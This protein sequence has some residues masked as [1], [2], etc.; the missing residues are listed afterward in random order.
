[1][2][3]AA[4]AT[5]VEARVRLSNRKGRIQSE[6]G[7]G[8]NGSKSSRLEVREREGEREREERGNMETI[9]DQNGQ[10][11]CW[12]SFPLVPKIEQATIEIY[13]MTR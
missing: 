1:M 12:P 11:D 6:G 5:H 9:R 8:G 4:W 10:I 2:A 3:S 7:K 13:Y